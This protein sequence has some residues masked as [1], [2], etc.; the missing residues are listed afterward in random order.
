A[1]ITKLQ[2]DIKITE[3][4]VDFSSLTIEKLNLD[5]SQ[6]KSDIEHSRVLIADLLRGLNEATSQSMVEILLANASIS[7]FFDNIKHIE[8]IQK[9]V[10]DELS[11]LRAQKSELEGELTLR[12]KERARYLSLKE[13]LSD[14]KVIEA[15]ARGE[16]SGLLADTK[17]K[18]S[19]YRAQ[20][21]KR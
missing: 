4:R 5:V 17:K 6:T 7:G 9:T 10:W 8:D 2:A 18:E 15:D 1:T 21:N 3:R 11:K 14:R 13:E 16:K 20:L 12:E 19:L